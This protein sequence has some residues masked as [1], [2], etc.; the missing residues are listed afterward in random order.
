[1]KCDLCGGK[2]KVVG[3][4]TKHYEPYL[5]TEEDLK[6]MLD[7]YIPDIGWGQIIDYHEAKTKIAKNII[8][9]LSGGE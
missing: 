4:T 7:Y 6:I 2:V 9:R 1:M 5:P 3:G 8:E